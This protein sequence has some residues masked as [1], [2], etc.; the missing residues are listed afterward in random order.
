MP[1]NG[2]LTAESST[3]AFGRQA[4]A[5]SAPLFIWEGAL[6]ESQQ[7]EM[8]WPEEQP[9]LH[10]VRVFMCKDEGQVRSGLWVFRK[11]S[12]YLTVKS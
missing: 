5:C 10:D 12:H 7:H 1:D 6:L 8:H 11:G 2:P 3:S 9:L 4:K